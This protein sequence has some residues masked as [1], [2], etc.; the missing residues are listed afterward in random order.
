MFAGPLYLV[1]DSLIICYTLGN[2]FNKLGEYND[3]AIKKMNLNNIGEVNEALILTTEH[4]DIFSDPNLATGIAAN[5]AFI[6]YAY[7]YKKQ[8]DIYDVNSLKLIKQLVENNGKFV[9]PT[10]GDGRKIIDQYQGVVA[11]QKYFYVLYNKGKAGIGTYPPAVQSLEV[12]DYSGNPIVEYEFNEHIIRFAI[13]EVNNMMYAYD[14]MD[15]DHLL[16]YALPL[17]DTIKM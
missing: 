17:I 12:F 3:M 13:D 7:V 2:R 15:E 6:V 11:G 1:Q 5:D 4:E 9:I 16:R 10:A 8:I 14:G